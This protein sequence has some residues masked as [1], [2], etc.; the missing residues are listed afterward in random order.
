[1]AS[2][3]QDRY[4]DHR[5]TDIEEPLLAKLLLTLEEM[6][7]RYQKLLAVLQQEKGLMIEGNFND[8]IP[9]LSEK[10]GLLGEL[11]QLEERRLREIDP[12]AK[13]LHLV[14]ESSGASGASAEGSGTTGTAGGGVTLRQLIGAVSFPYRGRLQSCYDLL[15]ALSASVT[16][17]NQINGL[18]VDRILRQVNSLL[19]LLTH[20]SAVPST[21]RASGVLNRDFQP[22]FRSAG[23][24]HVRG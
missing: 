3:S 21:Y 18:L 20:L 19:G 8:L 1:M 13:R 7:K 9:C 2:Q 5:V 15:R 11:K 6:V 23:S 24:F 10:E 4:R 17:I 14:R 12:L 16:E 22:L